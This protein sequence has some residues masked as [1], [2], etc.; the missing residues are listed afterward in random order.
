MTWLL[1]SAAWGAPTIDAAPTEVDVSGLAE[2]RVAGLVGVEGVPWQGVARLRPTLDLGWGDRFRASATVELGL[3][4]GRDTAA[5]AAAALG[6]IA[7]AAGASS[8]VAGDAAP[9]RW[10]AAVGLD[11][12]FADVYLKKIDL[13]VGRQAL[14]WG[15]GQLINPTDPLPQVLFA[16]PW[17]PRAGVNAVR[18]T[19]AASDRAEVQGVLA[20]DDG[21]SHPR[22]AARATGHLGGTDISGVAAYRDDDRSGLIGLD[23]RGTYA[24]GFWFEGALRLG[25]GKYGDG[26]Y[27][28]F[29]V[30]VD[31]LWTVLQGVSVSA[32]YIRNG[33]GA[34][35]VSLSDRIGGLTGEGSPFQGPLGG[36][37]YALVA[38]QAGWLRELSTGVAWLQNLNDGSGF[39]V[40]TA[41]AR[42]NNDVE[43]AL[44]AQVPFRTWGDG[45]E[46][47]PRET[48][49]SVPLPSG[50]TASLDLSGFV[51]KATLTGQVR[52]RY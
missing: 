21:W 16:E 31:R 22:V 23:V 51:P 48:E 10:Q 47:S 11:R 18:A 35:D 41:T 9:R 17:K 25:K 43:L 14:Q 5:E 34:V 28:T 39:V 45:G 6:S 40:A 27:E 29:T 49:L 19:V 50:G 7:R 13:R 2:V 30:G 4:E 15:S 3:A 20:I 1:L 37:D 26:V 38:A 32:Q 52:V 46:L 42:P 24:V 12:L 33:Q 44:T 8:G 36:R